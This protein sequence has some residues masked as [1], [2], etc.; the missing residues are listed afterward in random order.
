MENA[1]VMFVDLKDF[2]KQSQA[3]D[4]VATGE[5][6]AGFYAYT[7]ECIASKGWRFVKAIGDG[8]LIVATGEAESGKVQAFYDQL[9]KKYNASVIYRTCQFVAQTIEIDSYRCNDIFGKDICN[10]FMKDSKTA[11]LG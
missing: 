7:E 4:P 10:L 1:T 5:F 2:N 6:L 3:E 8:I 11:K 9:S